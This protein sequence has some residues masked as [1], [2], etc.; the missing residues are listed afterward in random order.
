MRKVCYKI[1]RDYEQHTTFVNLA[2]KKVDNEKYPVNQIAVRVY[3]ILQNYQYLDYLIDE[4]TNRQKLDNSVRLILKMQIHEYIFLNKDIHVICSEGVKLSKVYCKSA[5]GFINAHLRRV[6]SVKNLT[7]TFANQEKNLSILYSH[8]RFMTKALMRQY[9]DD[10]ELIMESNTKTKDTFVRQL[11]PF[12]EPEDFLQI[13][14]FPDL[15]K[16]TG[17]A[18]IR[19]CDFLN[20]NFLIQDLGSFLVGEL[21]AGKTDEIILDMCAAPGNKSLQ[22]AKNVKQVVA[23]DLHKHRV[24]LIKKNIELHGLN[25]IDALCVDSS[26]YNQVIEILQANNLPQLFDKILLDA[27]CSGWGVIK[28]KPEI[29]YNHQPED[30]LNVIQTTTQIFDVAIKILKPGGSLIYSTCTLNREEN[31]YLID[32]LK[33]KYKLS[34]VVDQRISDFTNNTSE[35][36]ICLKNY[37]YNSDS[38]FMIKLEKNEHI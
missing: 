26:D 23:F 3:G 35:L 30:I 8:P 24:E 13:S 5:T 16:Y 17:K 2:L 4:L 34:E 10:F 1:L 22:I 25:N 36:G 27:P 7:P 9:P 29:K 15:Y 14:N 37:K 28:S 18:A 21:V 19:H 11:N 12:L 38:F 33:T 20:N 6:E 32:K 31:D